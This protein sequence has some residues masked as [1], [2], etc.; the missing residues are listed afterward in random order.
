MVSQ[1][2]D[3]LRIKLDLESGHASVELEAV[4][5]EEEDAVE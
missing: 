5:D 3:P 1:I 2:T 4:T